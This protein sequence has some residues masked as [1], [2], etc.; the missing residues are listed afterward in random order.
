M[1][2][3][4]PSHLT[5]SPLTPL[6]AVELLKR[7][8]QGELTGLDNGDL[9]SDEETAAAAAAAA[10]GKSSKKKEKKS[11]DKK[12]RSR[13][14]EEDDEEEE[15]DEEEGGGGDKAASTLL[16]ETVTPRTG[17]P[18]L[19]VNLAERRPERLH[20]LGVSY[21]LTQ[22]L[23]NF[24]HRSGFEPLYL[25]Q[26]ASDTT[27]ENTVI[28]V[29]VRTHVWICTRFIL[30]TCERLATPVGPFLHGVLP[31]CPAPGGILS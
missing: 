18:P 2:T 13:G 21:G 16:T 1:G 8:Y 22:Q 26:S 28:M 14:D 17:L 29:K 31:P 9:D 27:G 19:L 15:G 24:W 7:Y 10:S 4:P 12:K 3:I 25:R 20:Y 23:Y 30:R 5:P 6:R 11:K